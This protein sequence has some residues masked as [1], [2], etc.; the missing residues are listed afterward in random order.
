MSSLNELIEAKKS[1]DQKK[2]E[3][4]SK[5]FAHDKGLYAW[6]E[7]CTPHTSLHKKLRKALIE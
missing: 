2:V 4:I 5:R 7:V 6:L 1:N 3:E